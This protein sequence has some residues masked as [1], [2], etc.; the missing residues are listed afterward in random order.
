VNFH[1]PLTHPKPNLAHLFMIQ[2][3][4]HASKSPTLM[5]RVACLTG[6]YVDWCDRVNACTMPACGAHHDGT[7]CVA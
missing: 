3:G 5:S 2:Y 4:L 7:T 1:P 6:Q